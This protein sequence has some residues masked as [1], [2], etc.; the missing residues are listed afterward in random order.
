MKKLER[1]NIS[2]CIKEVDQ[3][4]NEF[5]VEEDSGLERFRIY[6]PGSIISKFI[7]LDL[8]FLIVFQCRSTI[9]K[10]KGNLMLVSKDGNVLWWAERQ[11]SDDCYVAVSIVDEE[12]IAYDGSYNC[13]I[14]RYTGKINKVEFVK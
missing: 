14:D 8:C 13:Y 7:I 9:T 1:N 10:D 2:C 3:N 11:A 6:F 5:I 12:I 4:S